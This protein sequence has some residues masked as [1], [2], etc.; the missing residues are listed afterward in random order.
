MSQAAV[1]YRGDGPYALATAVVAVLRHART[2]TDNFSFG[3]LRL[4]DLERDGLLIEGPDIGNVMTVLAAVP[5]LAI[6]DA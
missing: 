4:S 2:S 6:V 5:G 3:P 1:H